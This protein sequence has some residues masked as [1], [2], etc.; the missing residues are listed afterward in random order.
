MGCKESTQTNKYTGPTW[1]MFFVQWTK[2][3]MA[4]KIAVYDQFALVE[5][6]S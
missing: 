3:K 4:A 1:N 5:T 2:T 6:L